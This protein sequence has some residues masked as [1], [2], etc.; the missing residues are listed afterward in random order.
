MQMTL[1]DYAR[2]AQA[3]L[4][5]TVPNQQER[6][7]MLSPQVQITPKRE[8]PTLSTETTSANQ[9]IR[10]SYGFGWGLNWTKYDE[11]FFKEGHDE[12]WAAL[13]GVF[14]SAEVRHADHDQQLEWGRHL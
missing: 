12:G 2:F 13:G 4:D 3:V 1:R 14:R 6:R 7:L 11:A 8:F 9:A 10:L 5:G